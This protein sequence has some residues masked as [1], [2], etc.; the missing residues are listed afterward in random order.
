MTALWT[1]AGRLVA[2]PWS[3]PTGRK[4]PSGCGSLPIY[5]LL[6]KPLAYVAPLLPPQSRFYQIA[7]IAL[8]IMPNG[9]IRPANPR[10]A[11]H[12]LPG[13]MWE[14]HI[15]GKAYR[16]ELLDGYGLAIDASRSAC[17]TI[18]GVV[19]GTAIEAC[20]LLRAA[21]G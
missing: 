19:P 21:A 16:K 13:G 8:P 6:D 9:D 10:R 4:Y 11:E 5:V 17:E 14:L 15:R 20:P 7:D 1:A 3:T 12:P 18:E 2:A